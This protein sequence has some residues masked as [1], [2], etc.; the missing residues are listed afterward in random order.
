MNDDNVSG[1]RS[2]RNSR[3]SSRCRR[4]L[5]KTSSRSPPSAVEPATVPK[6][7]CT[8]RISGSIR[9]TRSPLTVSSHRRTSS[10]ALG[11]ISIHGCVRY[12]SR[13]DGILIPHCPYSFLSLSLPLFLFSYCILC[14]FEGLELSE[15]KWMIWRFI[16]TRSLVFCSPKLH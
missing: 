4:S 2:I 14:W 7:Y 3:T 11:T 16:N 13:R 8:P 15:N 5:R 9:L 10:S 1:R 6:P 12:T